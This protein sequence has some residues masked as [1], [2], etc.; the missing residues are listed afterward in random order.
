MIN[1]MNKVLVNSEVLD[2]NNTKPQE[3]VEI[4]KS[5]VNTTLKNHLQDT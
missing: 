1:R 2:T 5:D 4:F 3:V